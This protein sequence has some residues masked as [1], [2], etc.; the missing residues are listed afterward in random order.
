M[1]VILVGPPG[2]GK[3]TVG[4]SLSKLL[5]FTHI[6][7][8]ELLLEEYNEKREKKLSLTEIFLLEGEAFF[9]SFEMEILNNI[10]LDKSLVLSLGG[11]TI[12]TEENRN[13]VKKLGTIFYLDADLDVLMTHLKKIPGYVQGL[14]KK[15]VFSEIVKSRQTLY[16]QI[17]DFI[18]P[19]NKISPEDIAQNILDRMGI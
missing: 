18:V 8:D 11:G 6:D 1:N 14:D 2:S 15:K 7:T 12:T 5:K 19:I 4:K 16:S 10:P 3:T 9:R 17:A 13:I